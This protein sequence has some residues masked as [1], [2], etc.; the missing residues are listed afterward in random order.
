KLFADENG[1]TE[2]TLKEVTITAAHKLSLVDEKAA[3]CT[4][5]GNIEHYKCSV[6]NKLF[7]DENGETELTLKEVTV[8]AAHKLSPV[9]EKA[10]T[11]T[12]DG[13]IEHYK[14]DVCGKLFTD[15]EGKNETTLDAVTI[16]KGHKFGTAWESNTEGHYHVCTVCHEHSDIADH[17][18]DSGTVTKEATLTESGTIEYKCK[19]CGVKMGEETITAT[20]SSFEVTASG[21]VVKYTVTGSTEVK[22]QTVKFSEVTEEMVEL[23]K[24]KDIKLVIDFV[25]YSTSGSDTV[26]LTAA[27]MKAIEYVLEHDFGIA[28]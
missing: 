15:N 19:V 7:A 27:Q 5:D 24:S 8:T 13:N 3:T 20:I 9:N 22:S 11:C 28:A 16:P 6:C 4:E 18:K 23:M 25:N 21:V 26:I 2:L 12:E 17:E 14:C 1:E 10:A